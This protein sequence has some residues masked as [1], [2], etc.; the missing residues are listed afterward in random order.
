M[1]T[2]YFLSWYKNIIILKWSLN[3]VVHMDGQ[4]FPRRHELLNENLRASEICQ[5]KLLVRVAQ[6]NTLLPLVLFSHLDGK[7]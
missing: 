2:H 5:Y 3:R 7:N 1:K 4:C 6:N